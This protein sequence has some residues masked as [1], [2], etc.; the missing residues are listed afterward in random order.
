MESRLGKTLT[1]EE[2]LLPLWREGG[3]GCGSCLKEYELMH[4]PLDSEREG[5][6]RD[7][8]C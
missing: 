3:G 5:Q 6:T 8:G 1:M 2:E 4:S 7:V